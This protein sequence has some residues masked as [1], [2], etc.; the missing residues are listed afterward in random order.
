LNKKLYRSVLQGA[1]DPE[2]IIFAVWPQCLLSHFECF[3]H[4]N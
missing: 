4:N 3:S 1:P 2:Y